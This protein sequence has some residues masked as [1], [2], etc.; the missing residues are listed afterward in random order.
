MLDVIL[1]IFAIL[2]VLVMWVV[3]YDTHHFVVARYELS[4]SKIKKDLRI[5]MLSDLHN[6]NRYGG[7]NAKLIEEISKQKPDI[8]VFAGDMITAEKKEVFHKTVEFIEKLQGLYP[9]YYGFGNHEQKLIAGKERFCGMGEKFQAA[10]AEKKIEPL[11]NASVFLEEYG[12][13]IYGV[14]LEH[15]YYRR[16]HVLPMEEGYMESLVGKKNV[17]VYSVFLAHNPDYFPDYAKWGADLVFSGHVHGGIMRLPFLGGVISPAIRFFPK[18]DGG[19]FAE[20]ESKMVL[21]RGI[22]THTPDI[23]VFNPGELVVVDIKCEK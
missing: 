20:A 3:L 6:Y 11:R 23:R 21:G 22:G 2:C 1:V 8:V 9:V 15:K 4:S 5:V 19:L 14:E 13:A 16:F 18:Y 12:V 17:D 7:G 10:L